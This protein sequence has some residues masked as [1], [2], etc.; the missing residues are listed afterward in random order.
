VKESNKME[1][2]DICCNAEASF[3]VEKCLVIST[4]HMPFDDPVFGDVRTAKHQYGTIAFLPSR[5]CDSGLPRMV[6][7]WFRPV[8]LLAWEMDC[9]MVVFDRDAVE[10]DSLKKWEW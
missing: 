4:A 3:G 10:I 5:D 9:T 1:I 8:L 7:P 6:D 2:K